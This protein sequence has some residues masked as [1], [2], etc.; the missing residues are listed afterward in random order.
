[1][2]PVVVRWGDCDPAGLVYFPRFFEMFHDAME[3]WF[4]DALG[5]PYEALIGGRKLG[6]PSVHT[7]A[8]FSAP[9]RFGDRLEVELRVTAMGRSSLELSYRVRSASGGEG[10][11]EGEGELRLRGRT[12]CVLMDLDASRPA[13]GRAVP[14]PDDLRARIEAF[15]VAEGER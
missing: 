14:W 11:G 12:V 8:D 9:C 10:E 5:Q 15:G 6:L 1:V 3:R 7:E 2:H 13:H 4:G